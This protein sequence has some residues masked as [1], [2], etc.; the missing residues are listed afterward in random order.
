MFMYKD[1]PLESEGG[2]ILVMFLLFKKYFFKADLLKLY[3]A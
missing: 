2:L 1:L 3:F